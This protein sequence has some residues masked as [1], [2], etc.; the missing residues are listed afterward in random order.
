VEPPDFDDLDWQKQRAAETQRAAAA[1]HLPEVE[2][3]FC[4]ET[5]YRD[6]AARLTVQEERHADEA[7]AG[8]SLMWAH[9]ACFEQSIQPGH[10]YFPWEKDE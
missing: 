4:G 1:G 10:R 9:K 3:C 7:D 6:D 5:V 2:C 8:L